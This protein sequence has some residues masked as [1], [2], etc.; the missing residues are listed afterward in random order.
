MELVT[1]VNRSSKN[2]EGTWDGRHYTLSP[3]KH[4][5]ARIMAEKFKDQNPVMGSMDPQT[6]YV[7]YLLGIVED[8]DPVSPIEQSNAVEKWNRDRLTGSRPSI[9]VPGDNGLYSRAA[10]GAGPNDV[11]GFSKD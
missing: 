5:F 11:T 4:A 2:L 10:L 1:L 6:L 3:G 9:T 8:G 7:D